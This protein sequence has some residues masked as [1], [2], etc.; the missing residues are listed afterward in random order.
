[1][2]EISDD[3]EEF[4]EDLPL[5]DITER[6]LPQSKQ[7]KAS[8][9]DLT[10][11]PAKRIRLEKQNSS[12]QDQIKTG[13]IFSNSICTKNNLNIIK[14]ST[15]NPTSN[16]NGCNIK[17]KSGTSSMCKTSNNEKSD[18]IM[19]EIPG[20]NG[21]PASCGFYTPV[22]KPGP[23]FK[24]VGSSESTLILPPSVT[25]ERTPAQTPS[26][27]KTSNSNDPDNQTSIRRVKRKFPGPAGRLPK[28]K[29]GQRIEKTASTSPE[30]DNKLPQNVVMSSQ[31]ADEGFNETSWQSLLQDLGEEA[32]IILDQF[33]VMSSLQKASKKLLPKG[34]I[35][36]LLVMVESIDLQGAG[37]SVV[38]K[39]KTGKIK[40]TLH[41]DVIKEYGADIQAGTTLV[42]RQVSVV[43]PTSRTHYLNITPT[44]MV[45]LNSNTINVNKHVFHHT[46]L[47]HF[48]TEFKKNKQN[49]IDQ[50][51]TSVATHVTVNNQNIA[52]PN[53]LKTPNSYYQGH[54]TPNSFKQQPSTSNSFN[55][56]LSTPNNF[57]EQ[58]PTPNSFNQRLST[59][60][61]LNQQLSTP[62]S[63]NQRLPTPNSL[64]QQVSTPRSYNQGP[65]TSNNY[66]HQLSPITCHQQPSM[67]VN[68]SHI[69]VNQSSGNVHQASS[70]AKTISSR[71]S[72]PCNYGTGTDVLKTNLNDSNV[73]ENISVQIPGQLNSSVVNNSGPHVPVFGRNKQTL[74]VSNSSTNGPNNF[75]GHS[76]DI[77]S[78][79]LNSAT[80]TPK[81]AKFSFKNKTPSYSPKTN[82]DFNPYMRTSDIRTVVCE[83]TSAQSTTVINVQSN[84]VIN[85]DNS[86][87]TPVTKNNDSMEEMWQDDITDELLSHLSE[88]MI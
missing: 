21:R 50:M 25:N 10:S 47:K 16:S 71:L 20:N 27:L 48:M 73:K 57:N 14:S 15:G 46:S 67:E 13:Q 37:A 86:S 43:S 42:L 23:G 62:N 7:S 64:N 18:F 5:V 35:P 76:K 78:N 77:N 41:R 83:K 81:T 56:Q 4:W 87:S 22:K 11:Q 45:Y 80:V 32:E 84:T 36:L 49:F 51:E 59:P 26:N 44:N 3:D 31:A 53:H 74:V 24:T 6:N 61:G 9:S 75:T 40:G 85:S 17:Q 19:N 2:F 60:N 1:M 58:L 54:S 79:G 70:S 8:T 65:S 55:R 33:S 34:K 38:L 72:T 29:P 52:T 30:N 12:E 82:V 88:E 28:L 68:S 69:T 39:D 66:N 63:F